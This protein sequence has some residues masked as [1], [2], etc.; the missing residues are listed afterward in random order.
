[1][2]ERAIAA[3]EPFARVA[4]DGVCGVG[5]VEMALR[6]AG[7][8]YVLGVAASHPF[9]SWGDRPPVAG[10]AEEAIAHGLGPSTWR[11][12]S[13]GEGTRGARL[14]D[15][16]YLALADL[17]AAEYD[18]ART[19][20]LWTRG[21]LLI[22]RSII[23]G[24]LAFFATWCPAGIGIATLAEVEGH[25]WAIEHGFEAAR[26]EL[27]L[28]HNE[29]RSWHGWHGQVALVTLAFAMMA[30]IR[31]R[32]NEAPPPKTTGGARRTAPWSAGRSRSSAASPCGSPNGAPTRPIVSTVS[33]LA[34]L[35]LTST[36]AS[37]IRA[38]GRVPLGRWS[39]PIPSSYCAQCAGRPMR[40]PRGFFRHDLKWPTQDILSSG[41]TSL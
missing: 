22:R 5:E 16:A 8:G 24:E 19:G 15:W 7:K 3:D 23:D 39:A 9:N 6:R 17:D 38:P 40:R 29:T 30:A 34:L 14:Y 12:L 41:A 28:D 1:M 2:S 35:P 33:I 4:A 25:R 32:A 11:R 10:T 20:G 21:G 27:G 26:T 36:K 37:I 31:R 18:D 13:A